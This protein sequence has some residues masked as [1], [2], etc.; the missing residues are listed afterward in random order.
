MANIARAQS[1]VFHA[2]AR[3]N[4]ARFSSIRAL[5]SWKAATNLQ[6]RCARRLTGSCG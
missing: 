1:E 4:F 3:S 6:A 5:V 2:E